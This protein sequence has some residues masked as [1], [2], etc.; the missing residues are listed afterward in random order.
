VDPFEGRT[1]FQLAMASRSLHRSQD[2]GQLLRVGPSAA[3][4]GLIATRGEPGS[5]AGGDG[6][7]AG[8]DTALTPA[9]RRYGALVDSARAL[10][11]PRTLDRV[12]PLLVAA[13]GEL[14]ARGPVAFRATREPLL[15]EAVVTAAQ[16][17][18]D[19]WADDDRLAPGQTVAV[20]VPVWSAGTASVRT[21]SVAL[22]APAG[23]VVR[24]LGRDSIRD[25]APVPFFRVGPIPG[26]RFAVT[27]PR[28]APLTQ[29][30]FLR[31][32]LRG[33][34]Y[35]WSGAPDALRGAP[36]D[37]PP[38]AAVVTLEVLGTPVRVRREVSH[39][40]GDQA[41]GEVRRP[42]AVV[43]AVGVRASPDVL[44]W[45]VT[46]HAAR[47]VTV[48]L[49]HGVR[50][51]TRGEVRLELPPGWPAVAAQR[52]VLEGEEARRAFSFEVRAPTGLTPGTYPLRA[53]AVADGREFGRAVQLLD[54]A[55]IRPIAYA[56]TAAVRLVAVDLAAPRARRI[57]YVRGASDRVP[58]ALRA[59]GLAVEV[60]AADDLERGDLA[61]YD[62]I[63]IGSRAYETEPALI[64]NNARLLDWVRAGGRLIVQYQQYPF[65]RGNYAPFPLRI[66]QPHDRVTDEQAPV[67][68]LDPAHPIFRTP[69]AIGPSDWDG[70][71]QE[72]GLYFAREWDGAYHPL[73]ETG[74]GGERL[75]GGLLIARVGQGTYVYTGLSFFRQLPAG[76][77]GALRLFVNLL[78]RAEIDRD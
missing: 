39:R 58:E 63:T 45:P 54:Y 77:P 75:R 7:F 36:F 35:D 56:T 1:Y 26:H 18:V 5:M 48:E 11:G 24:A 3:R 12:L 50:G 23:W 66:A 29:P 17:V 59:A 67:T 43:P 10:L 53:A 21:V 22:E 47:T 49:V 30:Y 25:S 19:G 76:V 6:L 60:L 8:V 72:R 65:V 15:E 13:L 78:S 57:G 31:H 37:P 4:L 71:V 42:L 2:M 34:L 27:V 68:P 28:D 52:F 33:A 70:W 73:L 40:F 41:A 64:A 16:V 9:L 74:D 20:T 32:S 51:T 55:H 46:N 14:R 44:V 69:N 61:R 38:L 62:V